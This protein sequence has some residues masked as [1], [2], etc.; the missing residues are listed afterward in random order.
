MVILGTAGVDVIVGFLV[1]VGGSEGV[2]VWASVGVDVL[3]T[4]ISTTRVTSDVA[5]RVTCLVTSTVWRMGAGDGA[6]IDG[7]HETPINRIKH[8]AS[9]R[10]RDFKRSAPFKYRSGL[11]VRERRISY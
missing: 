1:T 3:V 9:Q 2:R 4:G 11:P 10:L 6:A 5:T 8:A 7:A